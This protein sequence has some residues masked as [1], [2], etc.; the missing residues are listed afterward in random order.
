MDIKRARVVV[1][2]DEKIMSTF[3]L[4][5]LRRL[6]I[7][8][9]YAYENGAMALRELPVIKPDLIICDIHMEPVDGFEMVRQMRALA[10]PKVSSTPVIF[11]SADSSTT[12]VEEALPLGAAGFV[13]KPPNLKA[14]A[15]K[16]ESALTRPS[17]AVH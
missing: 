2:E 11:L 4:T 6:G 3:I 13:V 16:I 7:L 8:D 9:L 1:V 10:N 14:L 12:T 15:A 17:R 5:S